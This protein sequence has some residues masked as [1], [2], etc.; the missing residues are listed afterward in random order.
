VVC[1]GQGNDFELIPV[2]KTET[3]HLIEGSFGNEFSSI[4]NHCGFMAALKSQDVE[5]IKKFLMFFFEKRPLPGKF[6]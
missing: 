1:T 4:C 2:V 5:K 6:L 3:T